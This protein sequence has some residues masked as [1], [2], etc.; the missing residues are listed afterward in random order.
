MQID[1]KFF[2]IPQSYNLN[3]IRF[4]I[5]NNLS[6]FYNIFLYIF[7]III[8]YIKILKI[9]RLQ[10]IIFSLINIELLFYGLL[11]I[12]NFLLFKISQ[13]IRRVF[14]DKIS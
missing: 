8:L 11:M 2:S 4:N 7:I 10:C 6:K 9:T 13:I 3:I 5:Q 14:F 1:Y 12:Y